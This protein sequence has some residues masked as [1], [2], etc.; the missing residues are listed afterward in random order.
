M[1]RRR[2]NGGEAERVEVQFDFSE[3]QW[4]FESGEEIKDIMETGE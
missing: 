4:L 1:R 3:S 2:N